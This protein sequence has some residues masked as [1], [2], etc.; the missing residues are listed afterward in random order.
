LKARP[1]TVRNTMVHELIHAQHR[2]ISMLWEACTV[3]NSAVAIAESRAWDTDFRTFMER[4]VSWTTARIQ[5]T[6]TPY[7]PGRRYPIRTGCYLDGDQPS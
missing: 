6:V 5:K 7:D 1:G 2:D 4:F 3:N